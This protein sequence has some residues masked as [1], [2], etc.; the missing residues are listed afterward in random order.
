MSWKRRWGI[1]GALILAQAG[2][3]I[4]Y[5]GVLTGN[6]S[7]AV[8][9]E[10]K[11]VP[12]GDRPA[13]EKELKEPILVKPD[14]TDKGEPTPAALGPLPLSVEF[15]AKPI[16]PVPTVPPP[17][18][19][20]DQ[21]T[22]TGGQAAPVPPPT[23]KEDKVSPKPMETAP[24]PMGPVETPPAPKFFKMP[25]PGSP[26]RP[27][28]L[29]DKGITQVGGVTPPPPPAD[30]KPAPPAPL[31]KPADPPPGLLA[32]DPVPRNDNVGKPAPLP[33]PLSVDTPKPAEPPPTTALPT[34][35][36]EPPAP[37]APCPWVLRVE[38][39]KGRTL[40]TAQTG[41]EVQF[42]VSCDKLELQAPRGSILASGNV[43]VASDGLDG[44]C[45]QLTIAWQADQ[46]VLEGKAELKCR[47][48]GQE[49]DLKAARLSL[50]LSMSAQPEDLR[51][52]TSLMRGKAASE[53]REWISRG[54]QGSVQGVQPAGFAPTGSNPGAAPR[55]NP[56]FD[57]YYG[58]DNRPRHPF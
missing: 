5:Q 54:K 25:P 47:R 15:S 50:R 43:T 19:V 46:V 29:D 20:D 44:S 30:Q 6:A 31:P 1:V 37:D 21:V 51:K 18:R 53:S 40:M 11:P 22:R 49:V 35:T 3:I 41:K 55:E 36:T 8:A 16:E 23:D 27:A 10:H 13:E 7:P 34:Q 58:D 26:G 28:P 42:R 38:I 4:C 12:V 39:I 56:T 32:A 17:P 57:R 52:A 24:P 45:D 14:A 2:I 9:Q 33:P 48:E